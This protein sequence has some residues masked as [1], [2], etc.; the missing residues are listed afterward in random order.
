MIARVWL[1]DHVLRTGR[2]CQ[3]KSRK[4]CRGFAVLLLPSG[5]ASILA[6]CAHIIKRVCPVFLGL[7]RLDS[8]I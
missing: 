5:L 6:T 7:E 3:V 1:V 4:S 8:H 2:R